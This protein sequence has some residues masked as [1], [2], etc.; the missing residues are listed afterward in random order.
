MKTQHKIY[1]SLGIFGATS[2]LMIAFLVYPFFVDIQR[3]SAEILSDKKEILLTEIQRQSLRDFERSYPEYKFSLEKI[4]R[5][6]IDS[7]NPVAFMQFIE[8]TA[9]DS[10]V[11][12]EVRLIPAASSNPSQPIVTMEIIVRGEFSSVITFVERFENGPYLVNIKNVAMKRFLGESGQE[13][14]PSSFT[15]AVFLITALAK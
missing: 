10:Q 2:A 3:S 12:A 4:D 5:F 7:E 13:E 15:E 11:S 8:G 1:L 9:I 14:A 6:F